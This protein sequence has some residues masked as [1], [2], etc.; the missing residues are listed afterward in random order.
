MISDLPDS[1]L[2]HILSFLPAK[3]AVATSLLSKRWRQLW[4]SLPT[5]VLQRQDFQRF[6][7]F[8]KFVDR[9]LKLVDVCE[10]CQKVVLRYDYYKAREYFRLWNIS[11]WNNAV[12]ISN[13]VE[14]L[15]LDLNTKNDSY[16]LPSIVFTANHIKV[17]KLDGATAITH[18]NLS[19]LEVLEAWKCFFLYLLCLKTCY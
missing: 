1:L 7:F 11:K 14:H 8:H 17:L 13:I 10:V 6:T 4:F 9:M 5:L 18:V 3:E 16:E 19:L 2:L 12:I 15:E